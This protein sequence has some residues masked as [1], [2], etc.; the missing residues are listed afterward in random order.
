LA[1]KVIDHSKKPVIMAGL[2]IETCCDGIKNFTHGGYLFV[3]LI[4]ISR[5]LP[6]RGYPIY[7]IQA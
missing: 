4:F 6:R 2:H 5:I 1:D 3:A 7:I